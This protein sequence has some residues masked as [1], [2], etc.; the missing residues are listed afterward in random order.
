MN[1]ITNETV[2]R[3]QVAAFAAAREAI[4]EGIAHAASSDGANMIQLVQALK[5]VAEEER[6]LV[7]KN[8]GL[9]QD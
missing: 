9:F 7:Y 1:T 5:I 3:A 6:T 2:T 4:T 8:P